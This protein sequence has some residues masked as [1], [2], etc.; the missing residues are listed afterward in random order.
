M[1]AVSILMSVGTV[2]A[3]SPNP[4]LLTVAEKSDFKNT[5][6]YEEVMATCRKLAESNRVHLTTMGRTSQARSLPLLVVGNDPPEAPQGLREKKHRDKLVVFVLGNIHAGEVCGKEAILMLTREL[7]VGQHPD[8]LDNLVLL[9]API[10][11]A[12]GNQPMS[13]TNRPGQHGPDGGMGQRANGQGLDL[14]RDHVKLESPEARGFAKLLTEWDPAIVIDTHTTNGS[15]HQYT[16]TYDGPRNAAS[17]AGLIA[18]T[19]DD[20]LPEVSRRMED[21]VGYKSFYYGNFSDD[22]QQWNSYPAWPRYGTQYVGARGRISILSEAYAYASYRDRVLVSKEFVLGCARLAAER[23]ATIQKLITEEAT[24]WRKANGKNPDKV[25]I[26]SEPKPLDRK[27][28]MLGYEENEQTKAAEHGTLPPNRKTYNDVEF[29]GLES[30]TKYVTRP[31]A[32]VIPAELAKVRDNLDRHGIRVEVLREDLVV[33]LEEYE[34]VS[35]DIAEQPFQKHRLAEV[36]AKAITQNRKITAGSIIVKTDQDL[37]RLAT[38]LLEPES[39]DGLVTWNFFDDHLEKGKAFPVMRLLENI[40][41]RTTDYR[42]L[43]PDQMLQKKRVSFDDVYGRS[44]PNFNG[45]PLSGLRWFDDQHYLQRQGSGWQKINASSGAAE[46]FIDRKVLEDALAALPGIGRKRAPRLVSS[47]QMD[48]TKSRGIWSYAN[49]LYSSRLDG[50]EAKRLTSQPGREELARFSP[51]G[52]R[53]AYVSDYDLYVADATGPDE[54]TRRLTYDGDR[55]KRHGKADW[56]YFEEI[57]GRSWLGY[58]WSPDSDQI[59][60]LEYDDSPVREFTVMDHVPPRGNVEQERYPKAG[61]P[62]PQVRLGVVS[63]DGGD[64][65]WIELGGY[66]A[67]NMIITRFGWNPGGWLYAYIQDRAQRWLDFVKID[68]RTGEATR[69]FRES[70]NRWV[71]DPGEPHFLSDNSFMLLSDRDGWRH[72]YHFDP[73]GKV[74]GQVTSGE[75]EV[76]DVKEVNEDDGYIYFTATKDSHLTENLYRVKFNGGRFERLSKGDGDHKIS[77]APGARYFIDTH[78]T[79]KSPPTVTMYCGGGLHV[80][81]L[82]TNPL[83]DLSKYALGETELVDMEMRDGYSLSGIMIK[84]VD[85]DPAQKYPVWLKTYAGPHAQTVRNEWGRGR[86]RD[87]MLA[88]QG[89]IVFQF[90]PRSASGRGPN[91][92]WT[93]YKQLGVQELKDLEDA[94][95]WLAGH[96]FINGDRIG[97]GG[98]SYG[99]FMASYALTHSKKFCA[100]FAG[101]PVT[102][103]RNY[104]AFYTERYM[105]TPQE[106]PDGY[107]NTSV[108]A[109]AK[110]LHGKLLLVHGAM[111]DNVHVQNSHQLSLALQKAGKDFDIMIYP[112]SRHGIRSRHFYRLR[113]AF[114]RKALLDSGAE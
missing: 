79:I 3:Q 68:S 11:N 36:A 102:D 91:S 87:H 108:V 9:F 66:Q 110:D 69:L 7:A 19:R 48:K 43:K 80:R 57:Y 42:R 60:F 6:T 90:D 27:F 47:I 33:D 5:A 77:L 46:P 113:N 59:A 72:L 18:Y 13:P 114:I 31:F 92:T 21:R 93:A 105:D 17:P 40:P 74:I 28:T 83:T 96:D 54:R 100:G 70:H 106:N 32:Y 12:D 89:M 64:V 34:I 104:D 63:A 76:R 35:V 98:Y 22:H 44:S 29:I 95:D 88:N 2:D 65:K 37:G 107:R 39:Q 30:P 26:R 16:L 52:K 10:Y 4:D 112:R 97:I 81:T 84:P 14:N 109:A 8:L 51:D 62:I 71:D 101:A 55:L 38:L 1:I 41:L 49:N 20:F 53:I 75:W 73:D 103:W 86:T 61:D 15:Y 50:T 24:S 111:D 45:S 82:D 85:F 94:A 78:S 56:V 23:K 67:E 25:A 99:G 58:A